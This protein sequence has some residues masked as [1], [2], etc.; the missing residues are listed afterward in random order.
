MQLKVNTAE[1]MSTNSS[2]GL[3]KSRRTWCWRTL[4]FLGL[5]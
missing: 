1:Q 4:K 2:N 3:T 5:Y